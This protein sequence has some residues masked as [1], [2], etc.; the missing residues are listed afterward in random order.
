M[1]H[2]G[3]RCCGPCSALQFP[4]CDRTPRYGTQV[5]HLNFCQAH[6]RAG[7]YA[8]RNC[9]EVFV[10]TRDGSGEPFFLFFFADV[11]GW[12][13]L[14]DRLG[15]TLYS[16]N[17]LTLR[18]IL[19]GRFF[20][21]TCDRHLSRCFSFVQLSGTILAPQ[22]Q[23]LL[24]RQALVQVSLFPPTACGRRLTLDRFHVQKGVCIRVSGYRM[25]KPCVLQT[26]LSRLAH[27]C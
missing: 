19:G 14:S 7:Q 27:T 8:V 16:T 12:F 20:P 3:H 6:K 11:C 1:C 22:L 13:A 2:L 26:M 21:T 24:P 4:G 17:T 15:R 25:S 23:V 5:G 18:R 10:A 9:G